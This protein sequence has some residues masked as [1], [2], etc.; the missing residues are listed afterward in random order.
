MTL[1][2]FANCLFSLATLHEFCVRSPATFV[3]AQ[4]TFTATDLSEIPTQLWAGFSTHP[5]PSAR[6][7]SDKCSDGNGRAV[8]EHRLAATRKASR[9]G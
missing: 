3:L 5:F 2:N 9:R 8:W 7:S 6:T 1:Q 4:R